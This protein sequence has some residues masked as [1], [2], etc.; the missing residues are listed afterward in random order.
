MPKIHTV[1]KNQS[2]YGKHISSEMLAHNSVYHTAIILHNKNMYAALEDIITLATNNTQDD[3]N[4]TCN[5]TE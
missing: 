4:S 1:S 3:T 5:A 2:K